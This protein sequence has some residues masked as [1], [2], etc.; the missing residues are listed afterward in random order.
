MPAADSF[1]TILER[2]NSSELQRERVA[3]HRDT[4]ATRLKSQFSFYK[5]L[6]IGSYARGTD[7]AGESDV[8]LF[9]VFT[10]EEVTW[11]GSVKSSHTV[12]DNV[13]SALEGRL[14]N[15]QIGRDIHA[16]VVRFA[17]GVQVD[18]VPA[19]F[20]GMTSDKRFPTYGMPDG[21]GGWMRVSPDAHANYIAQADAQ[22]VG[23]LRG[24]ARIMKY[25]RAQRAP[26]IPLSSFHIE[27]ILAQDGICAGV[28]TY[29]TCFTELLMKLAARNCNALRDPLGIAGNIPAVKSPSMEQ[30]TL[31][32]ICH[33][34]DHAKEAERSDYWGGIAEARRQWGIVFNGAFPN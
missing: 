28:K 13:R 29:A 14:P 6:T 2:I 21:A 8:D 4:I 9:A 23:K 30:R 26:A 20:A 18:V 16:I 19:Y 3:T 7:I 5:M 17:T 34:R 12:L 24:T 27:M 33:C 11:G 22:S 15:T 31:D 1:H 32:S 25:W 10:K